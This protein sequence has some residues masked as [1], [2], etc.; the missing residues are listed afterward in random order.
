MGKTRDCIRKKI[1]R[2]GIEV[3]V[4]AEKNQPVL[5]LLVVDFSR[6][7]IAKC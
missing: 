3:V 4:H 1:Q 2:L 7:K 5:L 6:L